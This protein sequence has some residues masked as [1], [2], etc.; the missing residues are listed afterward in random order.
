MRK[1]AVWWMMCFLF[2]LT[3]GSWAAAAATSPGSGPGAATVESLISR[4][5]QHLDRELQMRLRLVERRG[6]GDEA[7]W[8]PEI[9]R[10]ERHLRHLEARTR[11]L[12]PR[13]AAALLDK[14]RSIGWKLE[15][16]ERA[17]RRGKPQ[18]GSAEDRSSDSAMRLPLAKGIPA[19][20]A[21][22][23]AVA[24]GDGTFLGTTVG[25][26]NDGS[27]TCG[28]STAPDVW[29]R[30]SSPA[31]G[32][33][34]ADTLGS[35]FDTV[36]SVYSA[37]CPGTL[38]TELTCNDNAL[39]LQSAV[40]LYLGPG[41]EVLI[42]VGG[43]AGD[44]GAFALHVGTGGAISGSVTDSATGEPLG[45]VAVRLFATQGAFS[46]TT[47]TD[48]AGNY[49]FVG[50]A[51][52]TYHAIA[53]T[54]TN[55]VT[56]LYDDLFCPEANCD[57]SLGTPI[58]VTV[59]SVT[60]GIDFALALGGSLAGRVVDQLTGDPLADVDVRLFD[61][62]GQYVDSVSPDET[63]GYTFGGLAPG[64][65]FVRA[66]SSAYHDEIYDDVPCSSY[67]CDPTVGNPVAVVLGSTTAG[68]DFGLDPLGSISGV[69]T[70]A[71]TGE[72]IPF[73]EVNAQSDAASGRDF[74]DEQGRY[75]VGGLSPGSY[76][77]W[78]QS[79]SEYRDEIYDDIPCP[80]SDCNL[81]LGAAVRVELSDNTPNIDFA[82]N[83]LGAITGVVTDEVTG[84]PVPY[85]DVDARQESYFPSRSALTDESGRYLLTGL[86]PGSHFVLTT[87]GSELAD[88]LYDDIPCANGHCDLNDG[89]PVPVAV[90]ETTSGIDFALRKLGSIAGRVIDE[91]TGEPIPYFSVWAQDAS[92]SILRTTG[93]G[94]D[95][96]YLLNKLG[97]GT[98]FVQT[99]GFSG[100]QDELYDDIPCIP[101]IC[102]HST[103][104]P[105]E[106]SLEMTTP[107]IDF[108]LRQLGSIGG[109]VTD[110]ATGAPIRFL[111]VA[112]ETLDGSLQGFAE[113]DEAGSYFIDDLPPGDYVV[114]ISTT[115][116]YR[117]EIYDDV[118]CPQGECDRTAGMPLTVGLATDLTGINF[119]LDRLG[120]VSGVITDAS[121]GA[122]LRHARVEI[123]TNDELV[124]SDA[125]DA[126]GRYTVAGLSP[127]NYVALAYGPDGYVAQLHPSLPCAFGR[128][129]LAAGAPIAVA[130]NA[131]FE[132]VDFAL[133]LGGSLMGSVRTTIESHYLDGAIL[134]WDANGE[135]L[136]AT[137]PGSEGRYAVHGFTTGNYFVSTSEI[138][139]LQPFT[140][141]NN[142]LFDEL[143]CPV[144]SC[145]PTTGTP[146][147]VT[148]GATTFDINFEL[149]P[150][151][152]SN[153]LPSS[154]A[155][156]L[157]NDRFR[158]EVSWRDFMGQSGDGQGFELTSDTGYFWFFDPLNVELVIKVLDGCFDPFDTFWVFAGGLTDVEVDLTVTD[159]VTDEVRTYGNAL[160]N[161]FAPIQDL[162]AFAT[163]DAIGAAEPGVAPVGQRAPDAAAREVQR[164]VQR[165]ATELGPPILGGFGLPALATEAAVPAKSPGACIPDATTL[166]LSEGRFAVTALWD[167]GQQVGD[168]QAN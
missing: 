15:A 101:G 77:V 95:G 22:A 125:S 79:V 128:C 165:L 143:S 129:D 29:F 18:G 99:Y 162:A 47:S 82:L 94:D 104:S 14:V 127:G 89:T 112:V 108:A 118:P 35:S 8:Q 65:Y 80:P 17:A 151:I 74:T 4:H 116:A 28:G 72:P 163:C 57:R 98:Y 107:G 136:T 130:L 73:L 159:T 138:Y 37:A 150:I 96:T 20:D 133:E 87:A 34:F 69:V 1:T 56:E 97:A 123:R 51:G 9:D 120:Q 23:N 154:T 86:H 156:C 113:T 24:I 153:C 142:E 61:A 164:E 10:F 19:N 76:V 115:G 141:Y 36:L 44:S 83:R 7:G 105:V 54:N 21:C 78:T 66:A 58:E 60:Q 110:A 145:D 16:L 88:E 41:E 93:T 81:S 12:D 45:S 42:R 67:F 31:G 148:Q 167:T 131:T 40:D 30:Y 52:G 168:G 91:V 85:F 121:T 100:Y 84:E 109:T 3:T 114:F 26:T 43:F 46:G 137:F 122:P 11:D 147:A 158:V 5:L 13:Q 124:A 75:T 64:D 53:G 25:A 68:I 55:L 2:A 71:A 152:E 6:T 62:A 161:A 48:P 103:G 160:G 27:S 155:L 166:C 63:G 146:V 90:E 106:V 49:T 92:G 70:D 33:I 50:L 132:N 38:D 111:S 134:I 157:N 149:T 135:F 140:V 102:E 139:S 59:G 126:D 39:G 119:A 144:V 32:R 117:N